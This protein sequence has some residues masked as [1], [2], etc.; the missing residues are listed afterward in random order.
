MEVTFTKGV[1]NTIKLQTPCFVKYG[2]NYWKILN[3]ENVVKLDN[4]EFNK[5]IQFKSFI[6]DNPFCLD[7]FIMIDEKDFNEVFE[8]V[9]DF[10]NRIEGDERSVAREDKSR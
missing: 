6:H 4:Y 1:K 8:E 10:L 3:D 7:G 5:G 2:S 9:L